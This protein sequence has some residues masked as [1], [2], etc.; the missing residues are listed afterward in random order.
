MAQQCSGCLREKPDSQFN[1]HSN[2][3]PRKTCKECDRNRHYKRT[4]G[5]TIDEYNRMYE[6]QGGVCKICNLPANHNSNHLCIDHDH[7][8][9]QVRAL[10]CDTCNRGLGYFKDDTR[11]LDKASEYLRA[12]ERGFQ[13]LSPSSVEPA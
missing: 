7:E 9:G 10:L 2:G 1:L 4:Y 8:T 6:Q 11:L 12:Y 3:K 5:I 13:D